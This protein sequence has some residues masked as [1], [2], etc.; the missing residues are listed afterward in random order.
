MNFVTHVLCAGVI[1]FVVGPAFTSVC[2]QAGT[3]QGTRA[4]LD[5]VQRELQRRFESEAIEKALAPTPR[6]RAEHEQRMVLLQIRMDFLR[7]QIVNDDLQAES[8]S[9]QPDLKAIAKSASEIAK[10]AER[11]KS[12]LTLPG[13]KGR[14]SLPDLKVEMGVKQ[15]RGAL[16]VLSNSIAAFVENPVFENVGVIDATLSTQALRDLTKIIEV[17]KQVKRGSERLQRARND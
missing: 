4:R 3:P 6:R 2:A 14:Q 11:L 15:L 16:S 7:I 12:N 9:V 5:P 13:I 17:S 10:R 1:A 8:R